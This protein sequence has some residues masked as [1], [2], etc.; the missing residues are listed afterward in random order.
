MLRSAWIQAGAFLAFTTALSTAPACVFDAPGASKTP[1]VDRLVGRRMADFTL[2]DVLSN[3]DFRLYGLAGKPGAVIVFLGTECPVG[4]LYLPRLVELNRDYGPKGIAF[5]GINAN[6]G[7][8]EEEIAAHAKSFQVDFP[9]LKDRG[10]VVADGVLAER[11]PEVL[12]LDGAARIRYRGAIDDQYA[13]GS[14]KPAPDRNHLREALDAVLA[15]RPV[16]VD[17]TAVAGC[18]IEKAEPVAAPKTDVVRVRAPSAD[19]RAAFDA[20]APKPADVGAVTYASAAAAI[21]QEKCQTCHRPGQVAP[22]P[23]LTYDEARKHSAMIREVVDDRRMP[24]WHADPRHGS[25]ANDRSLTGE[26]RAKLLAWID[27][28][29]PLGDP[30]HVPAPR[31]FSEGWSIGRP[32]VIF[33]IPEA[34]VVPAQGVLEY[35]RVRVPTK[36]T[37]DKWIQAAEATPGDRSVVHHIIIYVDDHT[38]GRRLGLGGSHFCGYAPGDMP[39]RFADGTAKKIPAGSDLMFEIHYTPNGR[40]LEDRSKLGLVFATK[41]V[42]REAF[43]LPIAEGGF[44]IPPNEPKV[45]VAA[46]MT[47]PQEVRLLSFMPHMHV[48]GKDFQYTITRP[49]GPPEVILSVPAYDFGWQ[50]YYTLREPLTLPKGTRIDCL[51]HYDNSAAN[52]ANPDPTKTVRW[53]DQTFEEMMIGYIDVDV[54]VGEPI[55]R[56]ALRNRNRTGLRAVQ[57]LL[58]FGGTQ[59]KAAEKPPLP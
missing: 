58:G 18:L 13:V 14:R 28:G 50:S 9:I 29:T 23:L 4:D 56:Q 25:F 37:E 45:P 26:D 44:I 21:L 15:R 31:T 2:K 40:V 5:V 57:S 3:R 6:V 59:K 7:D 38:K 20:L 22:F 16:E 27:Q 11:T 48:R 55:D 8:S 12:V 32:D 52:P 33:E 51:A 19:I 49:G 36:F 10:N 35:V 47:L 30:K 39:S 46:S 53:G 42:T 17:A 24:P 41:P 34:N 1:A 54:P 43:T